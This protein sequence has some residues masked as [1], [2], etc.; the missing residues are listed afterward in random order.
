MIIMTEVLQ[1]AAGLDLHKKFILATILTLAGNK[2]QERFERTQVGLLKL[3]D[4]IINNHVQAIGCE[5]TS[6]YW[7]VVHDLLD[8]YIPVIVGNARDIKSLS[9]KKTD[10]VDSE[11]IALLTLKG[12]IRPSRVMPRSHRQFRSQ[13]RLRHRLVQKRTDF[14]NE[15]HHILDSE[16]FRLSDA[17]KDVFGKTG[18]IVLNGIINGMPVEEILK[19]IPTNVKYKERQLQEIMEQT[20]SIDAI[21]RLKVCMNALRCLDE[22]IDLITR[23]AVDYAYKNYSEE[24]KILI[25]VPGIGEIGA[26]TLIA[27]IGNVNDF[28]SGDKLASWLGIVPRV[29]QSADKLRTSSITKRGSE[30][31]RWILVQIAHAA[32]RARNNA[33]KPFFIRKKAIIGAGKA[34]IALARK[35]VVIIWHLLTNRESYDDGLYVKSRQPLHINVKVP[36][37]ISMEEVIQLLKDASVIIKK[38]DPDPT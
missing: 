31:A 23:S 35:I 2:M 21:L 12:M 8:K 9:H 1:V 14:K 36:S 18:K 30:H 27:E 22:Q 24:M 16:L 37:V 15:I 6:D 33:L 10:K 19:C 38:R 29:Y 3:K 7:V 34:I 20:L 17:L 13:S 25:S 28:P 5:S 32:S 26:M 4:W 11:F